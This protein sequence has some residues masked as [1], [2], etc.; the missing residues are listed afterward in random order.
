MPAADKSTSPRPFGFQDLRRSKPNDRIRANPP[1]LSE[2]V[3][4][5]S[6]K[7]Y[8]APCLAFSNTADFSA[9]VL[10]PSAHV[11]TALEL[12]AAQS[13]AR[14]C[15]RPKRSQRP[16]CAYQRITLRLR[17]ATTVQEKQDRKIPQNRLQLPKM[18]HR[19]LTIISRCPPLWSLCLGRRFFSTG[20]TD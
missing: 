5:A 6:P 18:L 16:N 11:L 17:R 9:S 19:M 20:K 3:L 10:A 12:L 13:Q 4:I 15:C 2:F 14:R 8:E 1:P 7:L